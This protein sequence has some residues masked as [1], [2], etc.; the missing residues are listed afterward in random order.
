MNGQTKM[1]YMTLPIKPEELTRSEPSRVSVVNTIGGGWVDSFGRGLSTLTIAGNTGWGANGR[2]DGI[3]QFTQLRDNFIHQ[4]HAA[5]EYRIESGLDPDEVRL[6]FIDPLNGNYVADVV[7]MNFTLRRSR[8]HPLLLMY[9][10]VMTV[11]C[12]SATNPY[13]ELMEAVDPASKASTSIT[14][15][16][17]S[18]GALTGG[19]VPGAAAVTGT[20]TSGGLIGKLDGMSSSIGAL[21]ASALAT[22][23]STFAPIMATASEII[24]TANAA[25]RVLTSAEQAT[26]GIARELS[27]TATKVWDAVASVAGL[28]MA[29]KAAIMQVK[30]EFSNLGCVLSNGFTAAI[31]GAT[32]T[33]LPYGAS[34]CSSTA[35]GSAAS[36]GSNPFIGSTAGGPVTTSPDAV[37]AINAIGAWDMTQQPLD[38]AALNALIARA[39]AGITVAGVAPPTTLAPIP[40]VLSV[41]P[42]SGTHDGGTTIVI[43]GAGLANATGVKVDGKPCTSLSA[44]TD[45]SITCV[46]PVHLINGAVNVQVTTAGGR[47]TV[48]TF[49]SYVDPMDV[50]VYVATPTVPYVPYDPSTTTPTTTGTSS[51]TVSIAPSPNVDNMDAINARWINTVLSATSTAIKTGDSI[52][53]SLT[54]GAPNQDFSYVLNGT[55]TPTGLQAGGAGTTGTTGGASIS[56][57]FSPSDLWL[58]VPSA[59]LVV[60]CGSESW[61]PI[62]SLSFTKAS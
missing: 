43:T 31:G 21:G 54:G 52:S 17:G 48:N 30:G 15:M 19:I 47:N 14:S 61:M 5:R 36:N 42:N 8:S 38:H 20:A 40:T 37:A 27:A 3:A 41:A 18:V 16:T 29:A 9:N 62:K 13:P 10:I 1:G 24:A 49:F 25:K 56:I 26:V 6:I 34:N 28:P 59:Y 46:T 35:G 2:P 23:K 39:A 7:P 50:P 55:G 32:T 60:Y 44:N 53:I 58:S 11:V 33:A 12:E 4:W 57:L 51:P 45:T 22:T